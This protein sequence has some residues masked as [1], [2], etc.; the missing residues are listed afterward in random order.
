MILTNFFNDDRF[1]FQFRVN[2]L[3]LLFFSFFHFPRFYAKK[4]KSTR[5]FRREYKNTTNSMYLLTIDKLKLSAAYI[6]ITR[7]NTIEL[8]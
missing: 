2:A 5:S 6:G 4:Y 3:F 1:Q 8:T 7:L